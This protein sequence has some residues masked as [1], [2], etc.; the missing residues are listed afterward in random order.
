M[1]PDAI[2][3]GQIQSFLFTHRMVRTMTPKG[4][5]FREGE[6]EIADF[7]RHEITGKERAYLMD[8]FSSFG[9]TLQVFDG[10]EYPGIPVGGQ[11]WCLIRDP[12]ANAP[13][14]I[15]TREMLGLLAE[16][17]NE[18]RK[19]IVSWAFAIYLHYLV[20]AY[21][22]LN[23][24]PGEISRFV[25]VVFSKDELVDLVRRFVDGLGGIGPGKSETVDILAAEKGQEIE[26]RVGRVLDWLV[27][28]N[29]LEY[30]RSDDAYTQTILGASEVSGHAESD[31]V[32]LLPMDSEDIPLEAAEAI[33]RE[34]VPAD[35]G[36]EEPYVA[37]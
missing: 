24:H 16:K 5:S 23:R 22:R 4:K 13:E 27:Y 6:R 35:S 37:D 25:D 31:L 28:I 36:E 14:W 7:L 29:H 33:I 26:R 12:M 19:V 21:T 11:V 1:F 17:S 32:Y 20:L 8:L 9:F 3:L 10:N 30:S 15:S 18:S 2:V 34:G